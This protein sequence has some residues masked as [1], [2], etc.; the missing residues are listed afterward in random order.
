[1]QWQSRR[2]L[3]AEAFVTPAGKTC[4]THITN[5]RR[6]AGHSCVHQE[7]RHFAVHA[8]EMMMWGAGGRGSEKAVEGRGKTVGGQWKAEERQREGSER[9]SK[10]SERAVKGQAKAVQFRAEAVKGRGKAARGQQAL[11]L[12]AGRRA[13]LENGTHHACGAL[14]TLLRTVTPPGPGG[15]RSNLPE[16]RV[17]GEDFDGGLE[18]GAVPRQPRGTAACGTA[19]PTAVSLLA[20]L[21]VRVDHCESYREWLLHPGPGT[22][23]ATSMQ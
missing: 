13:A 2:W 9:P 21:L 4:A 16:D 6:L 10:G 17:V 11:I 18:R 5:G 12:G 19:T 3:P 8:P 7:G 22:S 20:D 23:T 14:R 1:M 15:T